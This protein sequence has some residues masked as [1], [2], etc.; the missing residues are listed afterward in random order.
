M[1]YLFIIYIILIL[2]ILNCSFSVHLDPNPFPDIKQKIDIDVGLFINESQIQKIHS[3]SGLCLIGMAHTWNIE[4]GWA[5]RVGAERTFKRIFTNVE[6]LKNLGEFRDKSLTLLITPKIENFNISQD[7]SAELFLHCKIVDKKGDVLYERTI[8][9]K[10]AS[11]S[12][13]GFLFGVFG[14]QEALS[15]TSNEAFN[16]AFSLLAQ[17]IITKIDF[18]PYIRVKQYYVE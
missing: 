6:I 17:D 3:Q 16:I 13:T 14:G 12:F 9:A 5:L 18:E 8:P 11:Q 15:T 7:L 2:I 10:G 1:R 4:T